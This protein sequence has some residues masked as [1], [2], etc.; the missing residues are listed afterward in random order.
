MDMAFLVNLEELV[1]R[2]HPL[3]EVKRMC[4]EILESL[5]GEF[6]QMYAEKGRPSVP[7]ERLLM[8]WVLMCFCTECDPAAGLRRTC[9][10]TFSTS[11]F[12]T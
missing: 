11:G 9:V 6:A 12:W 2:E 4:E 3:R 5:E 1:E 10:T 7:P 8:A